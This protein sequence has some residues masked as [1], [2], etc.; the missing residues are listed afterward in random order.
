MTKLIV[1]SYRPGDRS[2]R[3]VSSSVHHLQRLL[4]T[5]PSDRRE[6]HVIIPGFIGRSPPSPYGHS[7][8]TTPQV[9][10]DGQTRG[11]SQGK[12]VGGGSARNGMC[13][14]R[15]SAADFDAWEELGNPGWGWT[16]LLPYFKKVGVDSS[17]FIKCF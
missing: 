13:W 16:G 12:V 7:V 1:F 11:I 5:S 3:P 6:N 9:Y 2:R 8:R 10:L 4:L 17:V 14:T 15:G